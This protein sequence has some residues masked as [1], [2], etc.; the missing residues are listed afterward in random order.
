[1]ARS[2][3]ST[4]TRGAL[5]IVTG[6]LLGLVSVATAIGAY[7]AGVW[8]QQGS[9]LKSASGQLRD[10]NLA[11]YL[12][13]TVVQG[14]DYQRLFDALALNA[15]AAFYPERADAATAEQDVIIGAASPALIE[16]WGLWRDCG[17]CDTDIPLLSPAYE[18]ASY[19][20]PQSYN[21]VSAVADRGANRLLERSRTMTVVSVVFAVA[22]LLLGVA[23]VSSRLRVSAITTAGGA[24]AFVV[25]VAIV[26]FGV[27]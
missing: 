7:Q 22:L 6:V 8:G 19:A 20:Q 14:D 27:F 26:I 11:L 18:A 2:D 25:G 5:E 12:E 24:L 9:D 3:S 16:A 21:L 4:R 17:F 1:M 23:G 10:R 15:E 13:Y